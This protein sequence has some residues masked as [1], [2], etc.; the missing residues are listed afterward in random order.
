MI[1][2]PTHSMPGGPARTNSARRMNGLSVT[3]QWS[4][5]CGERN[6]LR[7][8]RWST[9]HRASRRRR[10]ACFAETVCTTSCSS[11]L[12][13]CCAL[14]CSLLRPVSLLFCV[15]VCST[16]CRLPCFWLCCQKYVRGRAVTDRRNGVQPGHGATG[17]PARTHYLRCCP[18]DNAVT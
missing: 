15:N 11:R 13:R 18:C 7:R 8:F 3:Q 4:R 9:S 5:Q 2:R 6:A 10:P 14:S 17:P 1:L 12:C 16:E